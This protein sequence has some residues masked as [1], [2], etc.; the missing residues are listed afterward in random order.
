[1]QKLIYN[2]QD[3]V[4]FVMPWVRPLV[5]QH[6]ELVQY[7]PSACYTK[8]HAVLVTYASRMNNLWYQRLVKNGHKLVVDHLWDSDVDIVCSVAGNEIEVRCP[9][10]MWYLSCLEFAYH[11]YQSYRPQ[12]K[13]QNSF[14]MLMNNARWHREALLSL[15]QNSLPYAIYSYNSK[16][17]TIAGDKDPNQP[18]RPDPLENIPWQRYMNP[19]WYDNTAFSVVAES[20]MRNTVDGGE[21]RTEVS[22]KIF[23]P[24]SYYHPFVVAG[25]VDTL[26]YLRNQGFV[27]FDN[28]FDE[29][30]DTVLNDRLRLAS[31]CNEVDNATKRWHKDEIGW[32]AETLRRLE[33]NHHHMF[34]RGL[35]EQRFEKEI[36][37]PVMEFVCKH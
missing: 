30:Y 37:D 23:K 15:L 16:G 33:H 31:V 18:V 35:V 6:F 1:M 22:E 10:W 19:A 32:D 5:E 28:W 3:S 14:L 21:M 8:D 9:N 27:T 34:D 24:L 20:Y 36:I 25:S 4:S 7:D 11:G 13:R 17:I 29:S 26:K 2:P 12:R